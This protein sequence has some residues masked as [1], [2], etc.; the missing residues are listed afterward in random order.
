MTFLSFQ[1]ERAI[2]RILRKLAKQ[3]V[4]TVLQPG[5]VWVVEG[6]VEDNDE[7][8]AALGL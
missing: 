5:D 1:R 6:A 4:V 3:R 2:R 7:T 8:K